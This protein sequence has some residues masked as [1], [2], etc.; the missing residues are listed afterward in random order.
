[1]RI[2]R[3]KIVHKIKAEVS[4]VE[5]NDLFTEITSIASRVDRYLGKQLGAGFETEISKYRTCPL[6]HDLEQKYT[7]ALQ[8]IENMKEQFSFEEVHFYYGNSFQ[9]FVQNVKQK[10]GRPVKFRMVPSNSLE[11]S[12][13][14][15]ITAINYCK[16]KTLGNNL[17]ALWT[18]NSFL[19][20]LDFT[21]NIYLLST[22]RNNLQNKTDLDLDL[23]TAQSLGL[24]VRP[25]SSTSTVTQ[26]SQCFWE[27]TSFKRLR[28]LHIFEA[29][30]VTPMEQQKI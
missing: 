27:I 17:Q 24:I 30:L 16:G 22:N 5:M 25:S 23:E 21:D 3:N 15:F 11:Y 8:E 10:L 4:K 13:I 9:T 18:M 14:L 12:P 29:F 20:D 6:D 28:N 19:Q 7:Q 2:I 1:M 26:Y